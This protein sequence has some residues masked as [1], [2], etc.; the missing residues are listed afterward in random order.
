MKDSHIPNLDEFAVVA[1]PDT[2][3]RIVEIDFAH[4]QN[5]IDDET[6]SDGQKRQI[7]EALWT[8]IVAFVDLG[9]GIHPAQQACGQVEKTLASGPGTDSDRANPRGETRKPI[10]NT[11]A[12]PRGRRGRKTP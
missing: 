10:S 12:A 3:P 7:V 9:F 11:A 6:L 8:F 4:Y 2:K 1:L 5:M